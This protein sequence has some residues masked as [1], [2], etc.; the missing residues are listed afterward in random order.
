MYHAAKRAADLE[1]LREL[2][3]FRLEVETLSEF[4]A[5]VLESQAA[6]Q[7]D[8]KKVRILSTFL[9]VCALPTPVKRQHHIALQIL[10]LIVTLYVKFCRR[11]MTQE[12]PLMPKKGMLKK[13]RNSL[14]LWKWLHWT[15]RWQ[16]KRYMIVINVL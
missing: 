5:K 16:R 15:R 6:L 12:K 4:R 8:L 3:R 1:K 7:R 10:G 13:C 2:D 14:R 9:G 11:K